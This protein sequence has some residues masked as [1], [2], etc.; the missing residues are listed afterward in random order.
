MAGEA[1]KSRD[2]FAD[3]PKS[4]RDDLIAFLESL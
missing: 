1:Q 4:T 2:A 3:L